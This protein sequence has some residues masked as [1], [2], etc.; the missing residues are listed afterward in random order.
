MPDMSTDRASAVSRRVIKCD[1]LLTAF[2]GMCV[3]LPASRLS[4]E[5]TRPDLLAVR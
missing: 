3:L 4:A 5:S 2:K 1:A